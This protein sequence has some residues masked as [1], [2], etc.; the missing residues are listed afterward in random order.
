MK[1]SFLIACVLLFCSCQQREQPQQQIPQ[2]PLLI[3]GTR[4]VSRPQFEQVVQKS[5]PNI[6]LLTATEQ[7]QLKEQ[8]LQQLIDRELILGAAN[9]L[10][11]QLTPDEFDTAMAEVRGNYSAA[12]FATVLK[13]M[14]PSPENWI[15]ALKLRLLTVKVSAA[16]L[17]DQVHVSDDELKNYYKKHKEEFRHPVEIRVRQ[18]LFKTREAANQVLQKIKNGGDFATLARR[19]SQSPDSE[20]GGSLGYISAGQLPREFDQ[21]LFKLP[22]RQ[23]KG[24]VK[25]SYGFHLFLIE[26]KRRPGIRPYSTIKKEIRE[27]L[28]QQKE[29]IAYSSWL[30]ELRQST[31]IEINREQLQPAKSHR[32]P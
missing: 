10:D 28:Y 14:T 6:S 3:V 7:L 30:K 19:Y 21:I 16:A 31:T 4:Q 1:A 9:Q 5:Y 27:K 25:S 26:D 8:L 29:N 18:M 32:K 24:P 13:Q 17:A 20:N 23:V 12:E 15:A 22:L 2:P 11:V